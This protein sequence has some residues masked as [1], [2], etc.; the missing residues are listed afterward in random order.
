MAEQDA[1]VIIQAQARSE[2]DVADYVLYFSLRVYA[3]TI[4]SIIFSICIGY[5]AHKW[6]MMRYLVTVTP[7]RPTG[8][9]SMGWAFWVIGAVFMTS[10]ILMGEFNAKLNAIAM[11][12]LYLTTAL[13]QGLI[14]TGVF[15]VFSPESL[16]SILLI[17]LLIF[18]A[19]IV[20]G[21]IARGDPRSL[22]SIVSTVLAVVGLVLLY[23]F[24]GGAIDLRQGGMLIFLLPIILICLASNAF[25][26]RELAL[27]M[28]ERDDKELE[29]KAI[30]LCAAQFAVIFWA[31]VFALLRRF[32]TR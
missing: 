27:D 21:Y 19:A 3:F 9:G 7:D 13:M 12:F 32:G 6:G 10:L 15:N 29:W 23:R 5:Y 11:F 17:T 2:E 8:W 1:N 25:M 22:R 4:F 20:Y 30:F 28:L 14:L 18:A 26:A 31:L 16:M 24:F